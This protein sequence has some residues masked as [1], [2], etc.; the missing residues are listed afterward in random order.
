MSNPSLWAP[1]PL[2]ELE[3][4]ECVLCWHGYT[5]HEDGGGHCREVVSNGPM[6]RLPCPCPGMRWVPAVVAEP[7]TYGG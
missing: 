3:E 6:H 1:V 4:V 5:K 7:P 2:E